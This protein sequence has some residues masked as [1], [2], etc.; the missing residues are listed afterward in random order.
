MPPH[1]GRFGLI[2]PVDSTDP[3]V[4]E[5]IADWAATEGAVA[6]RLMFNNDTT[7]NPA[8]PGIDRVLAAASRHGLPVN[9]LCWGRLDQVKAI[10]ARHPETVIVIDHLGLTQYFEPPAPAEPWAE[11]P[12]LLALAAYPNLMIK[13]S[14]AG[15]LS[16]MPYP[17]PDIWEPIGRIIDGFGLE[18]CMW[19]TDWTRAVA[20]LTYEQ[21]VQAFL[22]T[23]RLSDSDRAA[24]MG[25]NLSRV[26]KW[27]PSKAV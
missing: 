8:D 10:T 25:A 16:Q 21:G 9:V 24:L 7:S 3:A 15:T 1:P 5:I 6:I 14:G 4:G 2:K 27:S 12:K 13:I 23:E 11:M 17:Y 20:F 22:T 26:Y 19:G 18:R